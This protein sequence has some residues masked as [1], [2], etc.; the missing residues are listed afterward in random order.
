VFSDIF[1]TVGFYEGM[2]R[3]TLQSFQTVSPVDWIHGFV[4]KTDQLSDVDYILVRK[5][6]GVLAEKLFDQKIETYYSEVIVF[7]A[8][9]CMLNEAAGVRIASDGTV[10]RLL[11]IVDR[12]AFQD[13]ISSFVGKHEWRSEFVDANPNLKWDDPAKSG[14]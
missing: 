3:P 8:W 5:D 11:Q 1:V 10:L 6:L 12:K 13:A 7:Q 2:V 14:D 4:V 9:L